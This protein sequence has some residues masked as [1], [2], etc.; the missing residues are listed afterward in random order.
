[1]I[2]Y[3]TNFQKYFRNCLIRYSRTKRS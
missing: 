3:I 1:M 2:N